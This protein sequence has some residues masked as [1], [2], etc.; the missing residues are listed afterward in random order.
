MIKSNRFI[1][2]AW[3]FNIAVSILYARYQLTQAH[4]FER[5]SE[6]MAAFFVARLFLLIK[7]AALYTAGN[8]HR[9]FNALFG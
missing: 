3:E 9:E 5:R 4:K 6:G 7:D 2:L 1:R 8:A